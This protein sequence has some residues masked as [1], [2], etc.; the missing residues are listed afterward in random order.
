[1]EQLDY[2]LR[3]NYSTHVVPD[4]YPDGSRCYFASVPD[5]PG[6]ESHGDTPEE[7]L[8]NLR[9]AVEVYVGSMIEDGLEPPLPQETTT[10]LWRDAASGRVVESSGPERVTPSVFALA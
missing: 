7:A 4:R 5:L 8:S 10:V 3:L 9:D 2:Y 1:M 6:C